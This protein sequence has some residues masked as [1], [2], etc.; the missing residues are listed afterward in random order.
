M[1][2]LIEAGSDPRL[3]NNDNL[4]PVDVL[5]SGAKIDEVRRILR[6]AEAVA[7]MGKGDVVG[8]YASHSSRLNF[9]DGI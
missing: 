6:N 9:A 4:K 3:T 8:E 2:Q 7:G 5:P 1:T